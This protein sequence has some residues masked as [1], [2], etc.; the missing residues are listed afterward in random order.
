[1]GDHKQEAGR[2]SHFITPRL[3]SWSWRNPSWGFR[4]ILWGTKV[5]I[6][7]L[8]ANQYLRQEGSVWSVDSVWDRS[9]NVHWLFHFW[10]MSWSLSVTFKLVPKGPCYGLP[11]KTIFRIFQLVYNEH[12]LS[13][14]IEN[15]T[16]TK[17]ERLFTNFG[18]FVESGSTKGRFS[19][20]LKFQL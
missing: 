15:K 13:F 4:Y 14:L 9:E 10:V 19:F 2:G 18:P 12:A 20:G 3:S 7:V 16:L 8:E 6:P 5:F 17:I 11:E 1:M